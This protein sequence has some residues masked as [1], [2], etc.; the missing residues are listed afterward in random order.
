MFETRVKIAQK[1]VQP[2]FIPTFDPGDP[3]LISNFD[4]QFTREPAELTP[5]DP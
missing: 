3:D 1:E 2:P 5:E 4:A